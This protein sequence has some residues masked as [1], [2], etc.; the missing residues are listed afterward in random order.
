[1]RLSGALKKA[2]DGISQVCHD[3]VGGRKCIQGMYT[4]YVIQ[5][6][7][8]NL[9][10]HRHHVKVRTEDCNRSSLVQPPC[11]SMSTN[12]SIMQAFGCL[13]L[14][15]LKVAGRRLGNLSCSRSVSLTLSSGSRSFALQ[16]NT[17][18]GIDRPQALKGVPV[19]L[20]IQSWSRRPR[21]S[22]LKLKALALQILKVK[23]S[24]SDGRSVSY[25][26]TGV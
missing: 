14:P 22:H 13:D 9:I 25:Q 15:G 23:L 12:D 19:R 16:C 18:S 10:H 26:Q 11:D 5:G 6:L 3:P 17:L 2:T 20:A 21:S 8:L 1:M 7:Y 24:R 4:T